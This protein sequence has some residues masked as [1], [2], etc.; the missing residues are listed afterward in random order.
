MNENNSKCHRGPLQSVFRQRVIE[1]IANSS[2]SHLTPSVVAFTDTELLTG[3]AA[4]NQAGRNPL[5]T[6]FSKAKKNHGGYFE[7]QHFNFLPTD[8]KPIIG[9]R[10]DNSKVQEDMKHWPLSSV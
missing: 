3:D 5:N 4:I 1:V 2:D 6:I 10:F 7:C 8:V 9:R